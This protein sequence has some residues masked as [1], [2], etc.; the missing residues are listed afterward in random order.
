MHDRVSSQTADVPRRRALIDGP[1]VRFQSR[2]PD[3]ASVRWHPRM[4]HRYRTKADALAAK[5]A[6]EEHGRI[7]WPEDFKRHETVAAKSK[8][9]TAP[10]RRRGSAGQQEMRL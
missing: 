1:W 7:L 4:K 9:Q 2:D 5:E 6:W 8:P 10:I 3:I